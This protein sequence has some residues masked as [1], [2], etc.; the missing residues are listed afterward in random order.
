MIHKSGK[1]ITLKLAIIIIIALS[2]CSSQNPYLPKQKIYHWEKIFN[3]NMH[4][5]FASNFVENSRGDVFFIMRNSTLYCIKRGS[6]LCRKITELESLNPQAL[7]V[8]TRT[9]FLYITGY[10]M[11]IA[12]SKDN[13]RSWEHINNYLTN[14][15]IAS[16]LPYGN[17]KTVA[18]SYDGQIYIS[19]TYGDEWAKL[20][21]LDI[22]IKAVA[23]TH[24]R[25]GIIYIV[26]LR[27]DK[28]YRYSIPDRELCSIGENINIHIQ[29]LEISEDNTIYIGARNGK[30]LRS[31]NL[32]KSWEDCSIPAP[33]EYLTPKIKCLNQNTIIAFYS[34]GPGIFITHDRGNSWEPFMTRYNFMYARYMHLSR[35]NKLVINFREGIFFIDY[36]DTSYLYIPEIENLPR[37]YIGKIITTTIEDE[38]IILDLDDCAIFKL[39]QKGRNYY[40]KY[41]HINKKNILDVE[42]NN[43]GNLYLIAKYDPERY[44]LISEDRGTTWLEKPIDAAVEWISIDST[45]TIYA[46]SDYIAF[47][48]DDSGNSWQEIYSS[49][50]GEIYYISAISD[51]LVFLETRDAI[52]LSTDHCQSWEKVFDIPTP[53]PIKCLDDDVLV[54]ASHC[55]NGICISYDN[56]RTWNW[57]AEDKIPVTLE[58]LETARDGRIIAASR[59]EGYIFYSEDEGA[60]WSFDTERMPL[61]S[62]IAV[63]SNG[64]IYIASNRTLYRSSFSIYTKLKELP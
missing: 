3:I 20:D 53:L 50:T 21:D 57:I 22:P 34:Y 41:L 15:D 8:D 25:E 55:H 42:C 43:N 28:L 4:D 49:P 61:I 63:D 54:T 48:S 46:Y 62:A 64:Y 11:G 6:T 56:G 16:I 7:F 26:S 27:N 44:C 39:N 13:G 32:G 1:T 33:K 12:R 9:D 10:R 19:S 38:I 59:E 31:E 14:G 23:K 2:R 51:T 24:D 45:G 18:I 29:S 30:I 52:Y 17:N 36:P 35:D 40:V 58:F 60:T 5:Y 47:K 37:N